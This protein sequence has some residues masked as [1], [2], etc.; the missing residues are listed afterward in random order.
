M[1]NMSDTPSDIAAYVEAAR[2]S[3]ALVRELWSLAPKGKQTEQA[4]AQLEQAEKSLRI[5]EAQLAK[6]LGYLLCQCTFPP[7]IMLSIGRHAAYG[8]E[9]YKCPRCQKQDPS[10]Q[11]LRK[12]NE[13]QN[14][15]APA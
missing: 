7:Q 14:Y 12:V 2:G 11:F 6:G 5:A 3:L 15:R 8:N 4:A 10:E 13:E 9:L 1:G